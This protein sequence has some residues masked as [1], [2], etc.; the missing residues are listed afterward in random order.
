M[1]ELYKCDVIGCYAT[2]DTKDAVCSDHKQQGQKVTINIRELRLLQADE[3]GRVHLG[4]E[5][6]K[7][8]VRIAILTTTDD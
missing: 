2:V 6:A 3:R 1:G 8:D 4:T 5:Y 7:S